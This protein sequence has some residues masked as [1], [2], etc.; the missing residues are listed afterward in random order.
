MFLIIKIIIIIII[1][2]IIIIDDEGEARIYGPNHICLFVE[3][4]IWLT[5]IFQF[6]SKA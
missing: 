1:I 6:D 4:A 5:L 2:N 3:E